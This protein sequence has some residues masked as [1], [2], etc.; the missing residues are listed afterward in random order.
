[1]AAGSNTEPGPLTEAIAAI[2]HNAFLEQL[3]SQRVF[4]ARIGIPQSTL[5]EILN[6][7]KV[8]DI[9]L[10]AVLCDAL[11]IDLVRVIAA[12]MKSVQDSS[13]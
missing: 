11:D 2:L 4:G 7:S 9:E 13:S 12:A 10:L 8:V 3:V 6:G 5:S 1:V